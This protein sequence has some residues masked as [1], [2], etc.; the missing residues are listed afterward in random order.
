MIIKC[1]T[2]IYSLKKGMVILKRSKKLM[3]KMKYKHLK[4]KCKL[5][6]TIVWLVFNLRHL[7]V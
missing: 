3:R 2:L 1:R 7:L 5:G 6:T 4:T